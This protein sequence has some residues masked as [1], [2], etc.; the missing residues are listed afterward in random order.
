VPPWQGFRERV[1][2]DRASMALPPVIAIPLQTVPWPDDLRPRLCYTYRIRGPPRKRGRALS[3]LVCT[4][5]CLCTPKDTRERRRG[6]SRPARD[7]EGARIPEGAGRPKSD[8]GVSPGSRRAPER[9]ARLS[10]SHGGM[11][12]RFPEPIDLGTCQDS[13][14]VVHDPP[15]IRPWCVGGSSPPENLD[16]PYPWALPPGAGRTK[17]SGARQL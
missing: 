12:S 16:P 13:E 5:T 3:K 14:E 7:F 6:V 9:A 10:A 15:S 2:A 8:Y 11:C 17:N 4:K 1:V